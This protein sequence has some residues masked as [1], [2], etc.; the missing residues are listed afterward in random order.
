[1]PYEDSVTTS[2]GIF[3]RS[4]ERVLL[5]TSMGR[6]TAGYSWHDWTTGRETLIAE[7]PKADCSYLVLHP[8]TYEVEAVGVTATRQEWVQLLLASLPIS[9]CCRGGSRVSKFSVQS[10]TDDN[11][12]WIVM[13]HKAEQPA[14][15]YLL[16]RDKQSLTE[17][18]R[19]RSALI[20]YQLAPMN[21][22]RQNR[23]TGLIS[24]PT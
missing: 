13:A 8:T 19:A 22:S 10:Q 2:A 14:T 12:R 11:R 23:A 7:H 3:N 18:F 20:P 9:L 1:V 5:L 21:T 6:E 16:D 15:Y 17:L 4:N 24:P